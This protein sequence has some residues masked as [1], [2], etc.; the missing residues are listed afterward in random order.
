LHLLIFPSDTISRALSYARYSF[1]NDFIVIILSLVRWAAERAL[2]VFGWALGSMLHD[3]SSHFASIAALIFDFLAWFRQHAETVSSYISAFDQWISYF[4]QR[5]VPFK[6]IC[7]LVFR[8]AQGFGG[9][10]FKAFTHLNPIFTKILPHINNARVVPGAAG[11]VDMLGRLA[12]SGLLRGVWGKANGSKVSPSSSSPQLHSNSNNTSRRANKRRTVPSP[13][14][15][16]S[17]PASSPPPTPS[18]HPLSD[19]PSASAKKNE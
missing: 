17:S 8:F 14:S 15:S 11:S 19:S 16:G 7:G 6:Q 18:L 13:P 2:L 5:L 12:Q 4:A 3:I 1:K 9:I 10:L